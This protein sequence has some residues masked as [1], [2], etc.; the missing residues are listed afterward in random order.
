MAPSR[1]QSGPRPVAETSPMNTLALPPLKESAPSSPVRFGGAARVSMA[2]SEPALAHPTALPDAATAWRAAPSRPWALLAVVG[3]HVAAVLLLAQAGQHFRRAKPP[4]PVQVRLLEQPPAP[5]EPLPQAPRVALPVQVSLTLPLPEFVSVQP[6]L[7]VAVQPPPANPTPPLLEAPA[8]R[9]VSLA[10]P[11]PKPVSAGSLR[12]RVEPAIEVPR[13]SRR[14]GEAGTVQLRV[15]FDTEGRPRRVEMLRSS[16]FARLD[17]QALEAMQQSRIQP[18]LE[19]GRAIE[20]VAVATL[21]YEL[22]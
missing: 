14:A 8:P 6:R 5:P 3:V 10:A 16:G 7:E 19:D 21:E 12:Y 18:Y 4:A 1:S 15:V 20:V 13:L 2:A 11:Q 17:A 9:A 22:N